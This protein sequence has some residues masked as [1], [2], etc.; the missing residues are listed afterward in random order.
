M[1]ERKLPLKSVRSP[2]SVACHSSVAGD[3]ALVVI[4]VVISSVE[5]EW[6]WVTCRLS[7]LFFLFSNV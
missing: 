2:S 5:I 4:S 3:G 7:Y 6:V 1:V